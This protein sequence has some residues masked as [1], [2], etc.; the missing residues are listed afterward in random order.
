M[1]S[2]MRLKIDN[3]RKER[4][5]RSL[6]D[7]AV[8]VFER[9]GYHHTLISDIVA[10]SGVGQGT[11]YRY[12]TDKRQIFE[13]L[14][15]EFFDKLLGE[16]SEMSARPPTNVREYRDASVNALERMAATVE[17][18]QK[19]ARLFLRE[20]PSVDRR[21][22]DDLE[23]LYVEF[24]RLAKHYLDH[25]IRSGFARPCNTDLVSQ[26]LIGIGLRLSESWLTGRITNVS[27][28]DL[29]E[30]IVDFAFNGFGLNGR[31]GAADKKKRR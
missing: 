18:N 25:A 16:F 4:T 21:F 11:F 15:E 8:S 28:K 5:R 31:T 17:C 24:A 30:E 23:K 19:I 6:L 22:E 14:L 12:F 26:A 10:E 27:V 7:A 2:E 20:A 1:P 13:A 3:E 29:I 9:K